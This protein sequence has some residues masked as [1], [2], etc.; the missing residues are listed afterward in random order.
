MSSPLSGAGGP[1]GIPNGARSGDEV[2]KIKDVGKGDE[3]NQSDSFGEAFT[4]AGQR[5][6]LASAK[7]KKMGGGGLTAGGLDLDDSFSLATAK[8]NI[9]A[10]TSKGGAGGGAD[11][12]AVEDSFS[13]WDQ[14]SVALND[15]RNALGE[16]G[17][18]E[19]AANS[20]SSS[21]RRRHWRPI[22]PPAASRCL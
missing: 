20:S 18:D 14:E 2:E 16:S 19:P 12:T 17:H 5:K 8:A 11:A 13:D 21:S 4:I 1:D 10:G 9:G 3:L 6:P 22:K 7:G 15:S